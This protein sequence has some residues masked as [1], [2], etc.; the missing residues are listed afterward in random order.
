MLSLS[1]GWHLKWGGAGE[2]QGHN[3]YLSLCFKAWVPPEVLEQEKML[4]FLSWAPFE[5]FLSHFRMWPSWQEWR[6][7]KD[8]L[9]TLLLALS[10]LKRQTPK[11]LSHGRYRL[12]KWKAEAVV[13]TKGE[14]YL[15]RFHT[16]LTSCQTN[17]QE[18]EGGAHADNK[19]SM[20]G[21]RHHLVTGTA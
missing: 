16:I 9:R 6:Y 15:P 17:L 1:A 2:R 19:G 11:N 18:R 21:K 12:V 13:P 3:D 10:Q 5:V 20:M 4:N 14:T 7:S 8:K